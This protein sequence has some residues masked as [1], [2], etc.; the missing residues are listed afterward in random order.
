MTRVQ[1]AE[2][3]KKVFLLG[4][5]MGGTISTLYTLTREPKPA[6]LITSAGSLKTDAPAPLVGA[7]KFFNMVKP[8]AAVFDPKD[9]DFSR[10]PKV[11]AA[12]KADPLIY[13]AKGPAHTAAEL[14]D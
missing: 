14:I 4:H 10:D 11:V 6:G 8:R 1:A 5:S 3:A 9:E 2:P 13:D 7:V 12:M